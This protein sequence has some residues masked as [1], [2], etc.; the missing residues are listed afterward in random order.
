[1]CSTRFWFNSLIASYCCFSTFK[2]F[3]YFSPFQARRNCEVL[4]LPEACQSCQEILHWPSFFSEAWGGVGVSEEILVQ[5]EGSPKRTWSWSGH[6]NTAPTPP[7][8]HPTLMWRASSGHQTWED[9]KKRWSDYGRWVGKFTQHGREAQGQSWQM[10]LLV[11]MRNRIKEKGKSL[12]FLT[13]VL[14]SVSLASVVLLPPEQS[15]ECWPQGKWGT[16]LVWLSSR[17]LMLWINSRM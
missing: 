14:G 8:P 5:N 16:F 7:Y 10:P 15:K 4:Y 11:K 13:L 1:M 12:P 6:I 17:M 2:I 9:L 3:T